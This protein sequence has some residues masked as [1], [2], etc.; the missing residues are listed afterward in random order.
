MALLCTVKSVEAS[1]KKCC[2]IGHYSTTLHQR[3][4]G[5]FWKIWIQVYLVELQTPFSIVSLLP[6]VLDE[7]DDNGR[8]DLGQSG[9]STSL[10]LNQSRSA[11]IS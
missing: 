11:Q 5:G 9:L 1:T 3:W 2:S 7:N 8:L 10:G 4:M 6:M